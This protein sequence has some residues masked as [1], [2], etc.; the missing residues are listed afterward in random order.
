MSVAVISSSV[1]KEPS[2][3]QWASDT[4]MR[5][6]LAFMKERCPNLEPKRRCSSSA[7]RQF[8]RFGIDRFL[9]SLRASDRSFLQ[10]EFA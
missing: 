9:S 1:I 7:L 6:Y 3:A 5:D 2:E 10:A 8:R 4:G